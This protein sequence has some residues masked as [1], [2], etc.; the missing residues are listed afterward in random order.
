MLLPAQYVNEVRLSTNSEDE[1]DEIKFCPYCSRVLFYEDSDEYLDL[2]N[3]NA[4]HTAS[5]D[6]EEE[7]VEG[8]EGGEFMGASDFDL[9]NI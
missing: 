1:D 7:E 4:K 6:K 5:D 9:D 8:A 2:E 3:E